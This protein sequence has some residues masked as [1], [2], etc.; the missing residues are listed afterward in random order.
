MKRFLAI[1]A[2]DVMGIADDSDINPLVVLQGIEER[3]LSNA[4][5]GLRMAVNDMVEMCERQPQ[6]Y[7]AR[8]DQKLVANDAMTLTEARAR[9]SKSLNS[10]LRRGQIV[11]EVEYYLV[12]NAVDFA[13]IESAPVMQE[14]MSVFERQVV[15]DE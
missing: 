13:S 2:S 4:R 12:R 6:D 3:S 15:V 5:K 14:M 8:L 1:F 10:V 9:F 11:D 7:V